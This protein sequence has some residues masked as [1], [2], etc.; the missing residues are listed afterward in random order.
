MQKLLFIIVL[1]SQLSGC[2]WIAVDYYYDE[3]SSSAEWVGEFR[4]GKTST[5]MSGYPDTV[6]YTFEHHDFKLT[7]NLSYQNVVSIGPVV[8]PIIPMPWKHLS[9]LRLEAT[10]ETD[11]NIG[12][13]LSHWKVKANVSNDAVQPSEVFFIE[14]SSLE[15]QNQAPAQVNIDKRSRIYLTY[16]LKAADVSE[17]VISVGTFSTQ[18]GT[19]TPPKLSLSKARGTW[20]FEQF[21]L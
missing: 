1:L 8:F 4:P 14:N 13:D 18:T 15:T 2:S 10:I 5:K 7:L 9:E 20:H 16:P 11:Q 12:F 3:N 17:I 19:I 21:T 6:L